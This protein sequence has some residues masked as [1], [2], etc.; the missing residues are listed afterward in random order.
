VLLCI[1]MFMCSA[2]LL[3]VIIFIVL[4]SGV[5]RAEDPAFLALFALYVALSLWAFVENGLVLR[6]GHTRRRTRHT[7]EETASAEGDTKAA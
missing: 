3:A 2:P 1:D 4:T 7:A 6:A 5:G